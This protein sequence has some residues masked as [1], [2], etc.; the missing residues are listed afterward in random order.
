MRRRV[1]RGLAVSTLAGFVLL[2]ALAFVHARSFTHFTRGPRTKPPARLTGFEKLSVLVC[3]ARLPHAKNVLT[4]DSL[5][6]PFERHVFEGRNRIALEAWH[7]PL[8]APRGIVVGFHGYGGC[9][10][11]LLRQAQAFRA[12]GWSVFLVDFPGSGGSGGDTT[13]IGF[14]EA[15]DVARAVAYARTLPGGG[16][17]V[18]FG[19]SM[20]AAAVLKAA[21][22]GRMAPQAIIAEAP[23]DR[24]RTTVAHRFDEMGVPAF[25]AADLLVFWG[26]VQQ[27]FSGF[28]YDPRAYAA[29]IDTPLLLIHGDRD[30]YVTAG[31]SRSIVAAA[32]GPVAELTCPG[33]GHAS[34]LRARPLLWR[35]AVTRFLDQH[36][37]GGS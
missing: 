20:G 36:V 25:P 27:G 32:R 2:N 15:E 16:R 3:G 34:C 26:G 35:E 12:L 19:E 37:P 8:A 23:F 29:H 31:E 14:H 30:P 28:S 11:N 33:L 6:L 7:L 21:A 13:S 9:K 18:A 10:D 5:G 17:V 24:F 1:L 4:P 22:D